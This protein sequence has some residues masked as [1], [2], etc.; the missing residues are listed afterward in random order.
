MSRKHKNGLQC[1]EIVLLFYTVFNVS[2]QIELD[3]KQRIDISFL[4]SLV[5]HQE[6]QFPSKPIPLET[7]FI[8]Y[9]CKEL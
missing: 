8:G 3:C 6:Y 4:N 2:L 7:D 1:L 5:H 9:V